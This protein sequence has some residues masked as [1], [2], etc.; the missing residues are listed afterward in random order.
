MR[1]IDTWHPTMLK[2]RGAAPLGSGPNPGTP[3]I[4]DQEALSRVDAFAIA[5]PPSQTKSTVQ[6]ATYL[7]AKYK[8]DQVAQIRAIFCW[9]ANNIH[10]D[11]SGYQS[12][13]HSPQDAKHVLQSRVSVCEGYANLFL[14][15]CNCANIR[16]FKI[17]GAA[18]G[19]RTI[20]SS[21]RTTGD[22]TANLD[23]HAWNAVL[24]RGEYRFIESTWASGA[25]ANG[26]YISRYNPTP[27][28]LVSPTQFIYSH[29]PK[30]DSQQH[31]QQLSNKQYLSTP[32]TYKEWIELPHIGPAF[33]ANGMRLIHATGHET[34]KSSPA[35]SN[36]PVLLSFLDIRNDYLEIAVEVE[37]VRFQE[38]GGVILA[39]LTRE[40]QEQATSMTTANATTTDPTSIQSPKKSRVTPQAQPPM[41]LL[42]YSTPHPTA[43][44]TKAIF[45]FFGYI[46]RGELV[47][48]IMASIS[49]QLGATGFSALTFH[50]R[51]TGPG[52]ARG[53]P[54]TVYCGSGVRPI[55]PI[56]GT[57]K[58]GKTFVQFKVQADT[59]MAGDVVVMTPDK[60]VIKFVPAKEKGGFWVADVCVDAVGDWK[61]GRKV[62]MT[63]QFGAAYKAGLLILVGIALTSALNT[64][65]QLLVGN[66]NA[67][68]ADWEAIVSKVGLVLAQVV[69]A[70]LPISGAYIAVV[71]NTLY[72]TAAAF[73]VFAFSESASVDF[74]S[75][76]PRHCLF[77]VYSLSTYPR[78]CHKY[79][80]LDSNLHLPSASTLNPYIPKSTFLCGF[81]FKN[82]TQTELNRVHAIK[83]IKYIEEYQLVYTN[84]P[85]FKVS[86]ANTHT[87][88]A[89]VDEIVHLGVFH[90][91]H[92]IDDY[93]YVKNDGL[94]VDVY[95]VS[96]GININHDEFEGRAVWGATIPEG[97]KVEDGNGHGTHCAG[98]IS[99]K[100]YGIAKKANS[101]AVKVLKSNG[102]GSMS[103]VLKGIEF[104]ARD[105]IEKNQEN[106]S[107]SYGR[108]GNKKSVANMSLGGGKSDALDCAVDSTVS[109]GVHF[110]VAT[111]NINADA[112]RFSPAASKKSVTVLATTRDDKRAYFSNWGACADIGAPGS[113]ILSTWIGSTNATN[114]ISGTSMASPHV[115]GVIA[116]YLS[117]VD[118]GWDLL[119]PAALTADG[120]ECQECYYGDS[121]IEGDKESTA[122]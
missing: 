91:F 98:I 44:A 27:Y 109:L 69:P 86:N 67:V 25:V 101:I 64:N 10:Y 11:W 78:H 26:K 68:D 34:Q 88:S 12:G 106:A 65:T 119:E 105:H 77:F 37:K 36:S 93:V 66:I 46:P 17:S 111:G 103:D 76:Y 8:N 59:G 80:H 115:A 99:S 84:L 52:T 79:S 73:G 38:T 32:L 113:N 121:K 39:N 43:P 9:V 55:L 60:K 97:D 87:Q 114:I 92:T 18:T 4:L 71:D 75:T 48:R 50:V 89:F 54:P 100:V 118:S 110:A 35:N 30:P 70:S 24:I 116:A 28:F 117:R 112:C 1:D 94:G 20:K 82:I 41:T 108:T 6:L 90:V 16:A 95:V 53:L 7:T 47:C 22:S 85:T 74:L 58:V 61:I 57:L 14:A 62:E 2:L 5:T 19:I 83:G 104:V 42:S 45:T 3:L 63:V 15:L 102:S 81:F 33:R 21:P 29:F 122:V 120:C 49:P 23:G 51:N 72:S 31:H 13:R 96:T 40:E 107:K 56:E